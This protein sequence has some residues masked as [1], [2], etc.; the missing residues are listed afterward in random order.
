[1]ISSQIELS[2]VSRTSTDG[3]EGGLL[4]LTAD[5]VRGVLV[6]AAAIG[7]HADEWMAEATLAIR[8]GIQLSVL[9]DVVHAFPTYGEAFE[10]PLRELAKKMTGF[11][12]S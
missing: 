1:M 10:K 9:C 8:A 7:P 2:E 6:G 5:P 12:N 11:P 4:I 3:E